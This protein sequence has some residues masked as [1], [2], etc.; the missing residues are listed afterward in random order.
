M[1]AIELDR[2]S[3]RFGSVKA[4]D[5]VSL[6]IG[7]G[8]VGLLGPNGAGKTTLVKCVL[9]L[10]QPSE[11]RGAVLGRGIDADPLGI[12]TR[13]GYLP[14]KDC[15][16]PGMTAAEFVAFVAELSGLPPRDAKKRAHEV[17]DYVGIDEER[18]RLV[19]TFSTGMKQK[20]KFAQ[21]IAHDPE[22]LLLDEPT[23][24]LDPEGRDRM[25]ALVRDIGEAH[26]IGIV[27]SSHLLGDV[28]AVCKDVV[29]LSQGKVLAQGRI[30]DLKKGETEAY[31]V[32]VKGDLDKFL[33]L[34]SEKG[35]EAEEKTPGCYRLRCPDADK[36]IGE[37]VFTAAR[38]SGVQLRSFR[39]IRST[40]EEVF[41]DALESG[42][43][44]GAGEIPANPDTH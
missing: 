26:G 25:L 6:K 32:Q 29:I 10:L 38:D 42:F 22:L 36:A 9:G 35:L 40:L 37:L 12:R 1:Y 7:K 39:P 4:L 15:H 44:A 2:L 43:G 41:M 31:E 28:E 11:G 27:Y 21:A 3:K 17:L 30:E 33:G 24:G 8:R 19:D 16:I 5:A 14:E 23:N 34:L 20:V 13:V 18:Y